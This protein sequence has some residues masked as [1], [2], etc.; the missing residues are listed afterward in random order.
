MIS[1]PFESKNTG[2][3]SA[4]VYDRAITAE[5]EREMR[6]A[7]YTNGVFATPANSLMVEAYSGMTV[8]VNV[9]N[10]NIEGAVGTLESE[11]QITLSSASSLPRIDRIVARFDT[12]ED[13]RSIDIYKKEG[14][15]SS[16]PQAPDIQTASNFYEIVLADILIPTGTTEITNSNIT[17]KRLDT[18]VCGM[19]VPAIPY[20]EQTSE[21][22]KQISDSIDL[23]NSALDETTA[24]NLQTQITA[25]K[26]SIETN[27]S[28][29]ATADTEID[30]LDTRVTALEGK[31][32]ET[33]FAYAER[34]ASNSVSTSWAILK[35]DSINASD[36]WKLNTSGG[37]VVPY[38]C[39][40]MLSMYGR[41]NPS[42]SSTVTV[43]ERIYKN[44]TSNIL[45][46]ASNISTSGSQQ[47]I[48]VPNKIFTLAKGDVLYLQGIGTIAT[49]LPDASMTVL[50]LKKS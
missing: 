6:K 25:N 17:D 3:E 33:S 28:A 8:K 26:T 30:G 23:V 36:G 44:S 9:G 10:C 42:S 47:I 18:T 34:T 2:T 7:M 39:T 43:N 11:L 20:D 50:V 15:P 29:I 49:R 21:L 13:V 37:L 14:V 22:W 48:T 5:Q 16:N 24:G 27:A 46:T 41:I 40:V 38:A 31:D 32:T 35:L 4:P 19:V 45:I 12:S 1:F